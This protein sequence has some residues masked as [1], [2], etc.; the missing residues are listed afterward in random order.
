MHGLEHGALAVL[1]REQG[2]QMRRDQEGMDVLR[3][4]PGDL[5]WFGMSDNSPPWHSYVRNQMTEN[6]PSRKRPAHG[7][8]DA[9]LGT[10]SEGV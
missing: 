9:I 2:A 6:Q 10:E 5:M 8:T 1:G 7:P 4:K 3:E